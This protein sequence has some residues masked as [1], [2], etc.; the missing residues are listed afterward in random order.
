MHTGEKEVYEDLN[1][2]LDNKNKEVHLARQI[3]RDGKHV[4][5]VRVMKHRDGKVL[6]SARNEIG[7]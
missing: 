6:A 4:Q 7:R 2:S 5:H 3:G 1:E